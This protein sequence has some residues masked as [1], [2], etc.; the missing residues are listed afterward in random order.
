MTKKEVFAE[1]AKTGRSGYSII[2][3]AL[4]K[5]AELEQQL[6]AKDAVL[7]QLEW[8]KSYS[9]CTGWP[10]CP[11]CHG[12]K[13]GHGRDDIGT[14]PDNQGHRKGCELANAID[15]ELGK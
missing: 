5:I 7:K 2:D 15:K 9:Y 14:L 12:I 6:A 4:D 13:P 11:I 8:C 10:S 3:T 1:L